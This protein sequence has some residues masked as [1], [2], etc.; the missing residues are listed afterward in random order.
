VRALRRVLAGGRYERDLGQASARLA[1]YVAAQAA[2]QQGVA[3][4]VT[5]LPTEGTSSGDAR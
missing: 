5:V 2:A 3:K 4:K 1:D